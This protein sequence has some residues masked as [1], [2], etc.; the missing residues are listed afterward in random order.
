MS[1]PNM[2]PVLL[3]TSQV[4]QGAALLARIFQHDPLIQF[5][6]GDSAGK[7]DKPARFYQA[8]IRMGLLYGEVYTTPTLGGVAVWISPGNTDLTFGQVLKS[9]FLTAVCTIG[10][11]PLGRFIRTTNY[12]ETIKKQTLSTRV[13]WNL[14]LFGIDPAQQ[15]HGLGSHLISPILAKAEA[16][17]IPCYLESANERNL[18]F[19][20]RHGFEIAVH[21]QIPNGGPP[22]W[23]MVREP[24]HKN[25]P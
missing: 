6:L 19:Y 9:G 5:L 25:A 16:E 24:G 2:T 14:V 4:E 22:M 7:L 12:I 20:R 13:H 18:S 11:N 3:A 8:A 17:N 21:G 1:L 23:F 10:L 15:G